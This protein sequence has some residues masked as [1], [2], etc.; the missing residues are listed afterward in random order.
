MK[1]KVSKLALVTMP[2][3]TLMSGCH[4][5]SSQTEGT[6]PPP[7]QQSLQVKAIDGYLRNA[8]V[9]LDLNR[10]YLKDPGEPF[11]MSGEGGLAVLDTTGLDGDPSSYPVVAQAIAGQTIDEDNPDVTLS[12][13]YLMSAPPG[14]DVVTP[15]TTLINMKMDEGKGEADALTEVS[16]LLAQPDTDLAGDYLES[17]NTLLAESA[18][19]LVKLLPEEADEV[20]VS[21][22]SQ[23]LNQGAE[24]LGN[25]VRRQE[26]SGQPVT[27]DKVVIVTTDGQVTLTQD[28]DGDGVADDL[29]AFPDDKA[30]SIDTDGDGIGNN[31][32]SDDDNDGWSDS[33]EVRL[34]SDPLKAGSKPADLDGDHIADSEDDDRDG[35]GVA[36]D[37]DAFPDNQAESLDTDGDGIGNHADTDDDNDGWSDSEESRLKTD[38]LKAGSKPTDLDGDHIADSEDDDRDGD[39]VANDRDAFPDNQAE[40]IDTDG[41]GIG[42]HV[43]LDD[44]NDGWSDSDETRLNSDPLKAASKPTDLDGDHIADSED[45]DRDGDGVANDRDAFP[46]NQAESIDT[47]GDGIGNHVDLDDD[48]DGWSDSDETRL[49]TDPLKAGSTPADLD[50]DHIADSEDDDRDGD[51]VAN[52][53]DAFPDNQAESTD[54]DGDGIGNH[55]DSDDDND[56]WSDSDE[57]RLNSD[58]LKAGS[59]P[60]DLDGDHI[61]DSEDDD[62][63]GDG[64]ANDLDAFPDNQAESTDT[65]GDGIGNHADSDDDNDGWS[66]S[67]EVRL[68]S[69]PLKAG[70]KPADLDDD[71]IADSEDDD[72]DGDG[73]ANARDAFPDNQAE[74]IDTDGDGIG[75][76]ADSDDDNDGWSDSDEVRLN[77]DPLKAGS[78][79]ADLDGD[80]IADS[81]DDDRD[82]DGV[83]ND[84]DAFPDNQAESTDTDGD[85]IGNHADSDDDNDGWSDS[86]EVRLGTEPLSATSKPADLDGDHIADSEDDDRDGDGVA[87]DRDAFPDNQAESVDTDGDGIGNHADTDDDND[88]WSDSDEVRLGTDPLSATS[89]PADLDGDHIADSED[90][91]RDGDGV[92]NDL[93]AFPDDK[94]ESLDTDGDQIPDSK[95]ADDDNDG[96]SD[97]DEIRLGSDPKAAASKPAD[98]DGDFVAD[99]EDAFPLDRFENRDTN[100][101]GWGDFASSDDDGDGQ[102]D[103]VDLTAAGANVAAPR[104][105]EALVYY[106]RADGNYDGWGLHLWNNET[107]DAVASATEWNAPYS[108]T[109]DAGEN[110]VLFR[111]PLKGDHNGCMNFV[112]HKADERALG[113][114]DLRVE[115][116]KSNTVYTLDSD[117][118]A[119]YRAVIE[120]PVELKEASA[121]WLAL[122]QVAWKTTEGA[123]SYQLW[124]ASDSNAVW[125]NPN[126]K[127]LLGDAQAFTRYE[128]TQSGSLSDGRYP[129]LNGRTTFTT[130]ITTEQAKAL[131]KQYPMAVALDAGGK[132]LAVSRVQFPFVVDALY[133]A[134]NNDADEAQLGSWIA[135]G[136]SEFR[137]WAPTA[138]QVELYL[139]DEQKKPL[140]QSPLAMSENTQTGIWSYSGDAALKGSFFRYR[141]QVYHPKTNLLE[142]VMTTDPYSVSLSTG[143]L[144]SQLVDMADEQTKPQGWDTQTIPPIGKPE[145]NIIYEM[146]VRDFSGSDLDGTPAYNGKYLAFTEAQRA[147]VQH[148]QAL[149]DAGLNTVH[150]LPSFD[151]SSVEEDQSK[152]VDLSDDI[153]KLCDADT[154]LHPDAKI[155]AQASSGTIASVFAGLDSSS[156]EVQDLMGDL[157]SR[158][159]FNWGYDPLHYNA[160]EGS[161]A[162]DSDG[163]PRIREYRTM[164]KTLHDMGFRI[165]QDVVFNHTSA[166]GLYN[167]SVLDKVVP[168]Y[169]HRYNPD[170]GYVESSTCC[171]NTASEHRMFE[172]LV[173]DSLVGWAKDYKIDGF[174][175]DLMGHLM[176]SSVEKALEEVKKVDTDTWFYGEGWDFGE[177]YQNARGVNSSQWNMAGTGIGTYNDRLRDAVRGDHS[178][179]MNGTPGFANAGDRFDAMGGKLDLIRLGMAG[180]LQEYPIPT[181]SGAVVM[182][183]DYQFGGHGAG[184]AADP[185]EAV[186]Y[187][188]KHDNQTLWDI[189]QYK[190]KGDVEPL[191]RA[192]M[193]ILGLAPVMLGQGVPFLHMGTELL[194]S[195][196]MERD[197][198]DSGDWYNRLDFSKQTNNWNVGLP[199]EDK[200]GKNWDWIKG[201]V[202]NPKTQVTSAEIQWADARFKELLTIRSQSELLRL[203]E[204]DQILKRLRFHA[205]GDKARPGTIVMSI[206]D[207]VSVGADLDPA[208]QAL[209][210][211]INS[212]I[213]EQRVSVAG[214]DEF[215]LHPVLKAG[216]EERIKYA[217]V[218]NGEFVLPGLTAVVFVKPQGDEQGVGMD[219]GPLGEKIFLRGDFSE[220]AWDT[221][222]E[223]V[224][225]G[226]G[227]Y[228]VALDLPDNSTTKFKIAASDWD[229]GYTASN[230]NQGGGSVSWNKLYDEDNNLSVN[231]ITGGTYT[232]ALDLSNT[233]NARLTIIAPE[234]VEVVTAPPYGDEA[235]YLRGTLTDWGSGSQMSYAGDNK[236]QTKV[237]LQPGDYDFKIASADWTTVKLQYGDLSSTDGGLILDDSGNDGQIRIKVTTP[238][239]YLFE[240]DP[241]SKTLV[242]K[243]IESAAVNGVMMQ[244]FH[245][246]NSTADELWTKVADDAQSLADKGITALWLPPA[247][248]EMKRDD[249]TLGVGYATYDWYDLG[250]F[251]QQ[252]TVRTRYG[253]KD[254]YLAAIE[255]AHNAGIAIY[256]DVVLNHKFGA[257][258][259]EEVDAVRVDKGNRNQELDEKKISAWTKFE[260]PGRGDTYSDFKWTWYH[261][262]GVDLDQANNDFSIFKFRGTGKAWDSQVSSE[263]GNYDFLMGADLDMDHPD[264]VAELKKWGAWYVNFANLDGFRLD[265]IKHIKQG[266]FNDWLDAVRAETNKSLFTVGEYW[267]YDLGTLQGYLKGTG[268]RMSLFD[269]PLHLNFHK[270]SSSNGNFDMGSLLNGTLMQS[271]PA[272]AVTLVENHDTQP[273]QSLES[274]VMDWFKPLGYAFILLREEG[275]P[276][277]FY[278]DYYGA[279]YRD[280][281]R[282]GNYYDITLKSHKEVIDTLL[283]VRKQYAYGTQ[284][285]YLDHSDVIGWTREGDSAHP[286]GVAVLMTDRDGGTKWMDMGASNASVCYF[287]V[288]GGY[289]A[290]DTVCT[291]SEGRAE[292][293]AQGG[294]VSVWIRKP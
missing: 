271:N 224:Y 119:Y 156:A 12:R 3:V 292:F 198:Y 200:D 118:T 95:D 229:P 45:D 41:D 242:V 36:N 145:D 223:M 30:E 109:E 90:D 60:A 150:L 15:V 181:T 100:Q 113:E 92:A 80:H 265:A 153:S 10:N 105:S 70:S 288:M 157:R 28:S 65:D 245:W 285:S 72:R 222:L 21:D 290:D 67:D 122:D 86:D 261:F 39:G 62:R 29:D 71:H 89:K 203:G 260:F 236:Y 88:G 235:I 253:D 158:D 284:H 184:Y 56:G 216:N 138:K 277:I 252:G 159:G 163:M 131:L 214:A 74:S 124:G 83:A 132:P 220:T 9:W 84:R 25:E 104:Y 199:R 192:R 128:L 16:Q 259:T 140:A 98:Q 258:E 134:G 160:P 18:R 262:D 240:L 212:S 38:P 176:K 6:K 57:T 191:D 22:A 278:A 162:H 281:G 54:T 201:I 275:Y 254:Q 248:K 183:R 171:D 251:N 196:S 141:V 120:T 114:D 68:N 186:N 228:E 219:V 143:S 189:N 53:L 1:F 135:D 234:G 46:D 166:S 91:D 4:D 11:A 59:K 130:D 255:S 34:N 146:H 233:S 165:I 202:A 175:F 147:S 115:L 209:V 178:D 125:V 82:G 52:N 210:V 44:D 213:W 66:E 73:V 264:V 103:S 231:V 137:L 148:L 197:S 139:Y 2:L 51:G 280:K 106:K 27:L 204:K 226:Q 142:W 87:N 107:C 205:L 149:R 85:G 117:P 108:V 180:N 282:D 5:N 116:H 77:S 33:D 294:S 276:N 221:S 256:A 26:A 63:D 129:H 237:H 230:L 81:E 20:S 289:A 152:R 187:V 14:T 75:N 43:D 151:I 170:S 293:K 24:L 273:L 8:Q 69:D 155:C 283:D 211:A 244:Y 190:A 154:G 168:G 257:D 76:H 32:D 172:K 164:V 40:S 161:Y 266:F 167:T 274:P 31:A 58:P 250:E 263:F 195:K 269:A 206:D 50:G 185:Q 61:A 79:P 37:R 291:N 55:A 177:V 243:V 232:F 35:D 78:K 49:K 249:G 268:Y 42:N 17:G 19:A 246:Y 194:R 123:A 136:Q 270:A 227:L 94:S 188:S 287:D 218:E 193:Q 215:E 48:N 217:R 127:T 267:D 239:Q 241:V 47:D 179:P 23:V 144:Y 286:Q 93:D 173:A 110:G 99:S 64:V 169:Y 7:P 126:G 96:W 208:Y 182:G 112:V 121:H 279:S 13:G 238:G 102:P 97:T 101:D 174:R 133:T 225:K 207:G 111:V 272:Q 247:Y